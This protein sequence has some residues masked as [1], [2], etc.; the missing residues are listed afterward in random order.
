[1]SSLVGGTVQPLGG[2]VAETT[3]R[4]VTFNSNTYP[5]TVLSAAFSLH[6][7]YL[8]LTDCCNFH[9]LQVITA[10]TPSPNRA[11]KHPRNPTTPILPLVDPPRGGYDGKPDDTLPYYYDT[12]RIEEFKDFRL[13]TPV[14]FPSFQANNPL[15]IPISDMPSSLGGGSTYDT[16]LVTES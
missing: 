15:V 9:W 5:E 7:N 6:S 12:T 14:I 4:Q 10:K 3:Q 11:L 1:V 2:I 13:N 16:W 8:Y